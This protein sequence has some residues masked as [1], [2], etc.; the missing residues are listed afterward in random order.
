MYFK[1]CLKIASRNSARLGVHS[2]HILCHASCMF[3]SQV[4]YCQIRVIGKAVRPLFADPATYAIQ[5]NIS[6][7]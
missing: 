2:D 4:M 1:Y 3:L 7:A 5:I 6:I